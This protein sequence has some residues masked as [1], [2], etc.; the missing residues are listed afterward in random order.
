MAEPVKVKG[1]AVSSTLRYLA[2]KHGPASLE[3]V[4][5]ALP[6][7]ERDAFRRGVLVS[8]W[9][10][11]GA[12]AQMMREA[13]GLYG[14]GGNAIYKEMGRASADYALTTIYKIFF[15]VGSPQFI[16][17]RA[18]S[19]YGSYYSAGGAKVTES[20]RGFAILE[21]DPFPEPCEEYCHRV[22][23]WVDR[24]L[25]LSGASRVESKHEVCQAKG[26]PQCRIEGH[27]VGS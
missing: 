4:T 7:E 16:I 17:T 21:L 24:M 26:D 20:G 3:A 25:E 14:G 13:R 19:V 27:W 9:Y 23:G 22:W 12:L 1:T 18:A 6:P 2:E 8:Q 10:R 11:F 15:K 5:A